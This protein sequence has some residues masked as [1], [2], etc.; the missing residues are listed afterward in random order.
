LIRNEGKK[1]D[2]K[3]LRKVYISFRA[4]VGLFLNLLSFLFWSIVSLFSK[5]GKTPPIKNL[6]QTSISTNVDS[7]WNVHTVIGSELSHVKTAY[8]SKKYLEWRFSVY[9]LFRELMRLWGNHDNEVILDYGCGP[10]NDLTGFLVNTRAER[11]IG[12]D[13]SEKALKFASKRLALHNID[14]ERV[15]LIR[16]S[17]DVAKIPLEN[18]TIDYVYCEGVLH[19]TTTPEGIIKEFHRVLKPNSRACIMVYNNDSIWFHLYVAYEQMILENRYPGLDEYQAFTKTTDTEECPIARCYKPQEFISICEKSGFKAE[20]M[21]GYFSLLELDL[22]KKYIPT[23]LEDKR[24]A[25]E[26][27]DFLKSLVLDEK[28][29]PQYKGKHAGI[30]GVYKLY[31]AE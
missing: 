4:V 26:H 2:M 27:K 25:I 6:E 10:G 31:K 28:G 24:L 8:Q 18:N 29:F 14:N 3:F 16:I 17:D 19:H 23:A 20:Y 15:E 9:P 11:V 12:V 13:I 1:Y 30:G 22:F 7:F 21:G 5:K